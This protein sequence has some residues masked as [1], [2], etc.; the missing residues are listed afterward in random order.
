MEVFDAHNHLHF[1]EREG[2]LRRSELTGISGAVVNGTQETDWEEVVKICTD[3]RNPIHGEQFAHQ[4]EVR[5]I[6]S[7]GLHPWYVSQRTPEW[8]ERLKQSLDTAPS[9]IGEIGLDRWM[10]NFDWEA[11]QQVFQA[12]LRIASER[13]LPI[14]IHCLKAWGKLLETLGESPRLKPGFLLHSYSGP[15]EMMAS[16]IEL[17]AYFSFSGYFAH[18][19]KERQRSAFK[20]VPIERLLVETDAP[21]MLPPP[22]LQ[23]FSIVK[24]GPTGDTRHLNHPANILAVYE[25]CAELRGIPLEEFSQQIAANFK[26]LFGRLL[27]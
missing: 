4:G 19:R 18:S 20:L 8:E 23:R 17:G 9:A 15:A 6:P 10:Q 24:T 7:L 5:L 16:F 11:Q 1:L 14:T 12:Q 13:H 26:A 2:L 25:Y 22:E 21:D 3:Y 27:P